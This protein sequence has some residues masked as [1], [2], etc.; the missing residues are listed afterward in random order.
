MTTTP[1]VACS[2]ISH[3][4]GSGETR[5]QILFSCDV[6]VGTGEVVVMTGPS[7]SGKSTLLT[8][9]GGLRS[10]QEGSLRVLGTEMRDLSPAGLIEARRQVGFIFQAHNLFDSLSARENV[11][12]GLDLKDMT[13]RQRRE[14]AD[15][16]LQAVGLGERITYRPGALS[17]GQRQR[18]AIARAL[19]P[20]PRIVLADEP[21]AALD[22]E[23]GRKVVGLFQQMAADG[24]T[25]F[26][27]THDKRV[28]DA[29][30]RI[31][32]MLDGRIASDVRP[33]R[34]LQL[35]EFLSKVPAFSTLTPAALS[36]V[37]EQLREQRV[38][39]GATVVREGE[40]GDAFYLIGEGSVAVTIKE[41]EV[42]TLA[43][44][45]FFG[46]AALLKGEP[47]NATVTSRESTLLYVLDKAHFD[48]ALERSG[49]MRKQL[50]EVLF[51]R[52]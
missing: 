3:Y 31:V 18:V 48:R 44:G 5:K 42:A 7:G 52:Q 50:L 32:H 34:A 16:M 47:R 23:T 21:T 15:E 26:L 40:A 43:T 39:A 1:S 12:M 2:G 27:V 37:S 6:T 17:G 19:A 11:Q 36:E 20:R 28:L 35:A 33:R 30:D 13:P 49:D 46:E 25:I 14:R 41:R 51:Q 45:Q 29:S 10:I 4:F 9:I 24:C 8:L 22:G 38:G